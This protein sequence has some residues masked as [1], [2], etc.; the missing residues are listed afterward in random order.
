M[1][2]AQLAS[3]RICS[4]GPAHRVDVGGLG[5]SLRAQV[6]DARGRG[7]GGGVALAEPEGGIQRRP[8]RRASSSQVA[9]ERRVDLGHDQRGSPGSAAGR[10]PRCPRAAPG[11]RNGRPPCAKREGRRALRSGADVLQQLAQLVRRV[12]QHRRPHGP[13]HWWAP[14]SCSPPPLRRSLTRRT[15]IDLAGLVMSP[16]GVL[17]YDRAT[18]CVRA[19]GYPWNHRKPPRFP[20]PRRHVRGARGAP[21]RAPRKSCS[22]C[23]RSTSTS[24]SGAASRGRPRRD[25]VAERRSSSRARPPRSRPP[26]CSARPS[27]GARSFAPKA[28]T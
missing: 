1:R 4:S 27:G 9:L 15:L 20:R 2:D 24:S 28:R 13:G 26:S 14:R 18:S 7:G 11:A 17:D 19:W 12:R 3:R 10:L 8:A 5:Q 16:A 23:P 21:P 6:G 22:S 25:A